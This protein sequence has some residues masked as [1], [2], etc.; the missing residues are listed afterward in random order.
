MLIIY[1]GLIDDEQQRVKFEEIYTTYRMQMIHLA[2]SY[3]ENKADAEDVVHDVFVRIATK[4]MKFIQ[5]LG[6]PKDI[7][8]Y[9]LKA[10]KNTALNELKRKGRSNI[11]I[12][13]VA[14]S[15]LDSFP[16]LSDDSFIEMICTKAEYECVVQELLFMEEPY[17]DIMYYHFVLDLT[18]PEAA[19]LLGR[20]ITTAK[21]Q[22]VRGKKLLLYKLEIRGDLKNGHD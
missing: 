16:D 11:S 9:L 12:E 13:D 18:V 19:K 20:N 3:F 22:L 14:E 7:R 2:K 15:D 21:K 8:N 17:R 10:T 4:H 6:N 5:G 1:L